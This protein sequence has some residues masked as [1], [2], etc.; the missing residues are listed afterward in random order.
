MNGEGSRERATQGGGAMTARRSIG[1]LSRTLVC[2]CAALAL[3]AG[4]AQGAAEPHPHVGKLPGFPMI[5]GVVPVLGSKAAVSAHEKLVKDAFSTVRA[6]HAKGL[7]GAPVSNEEP[8][9]ECEE[10]AFFFASQD[11]CYRG[12]PVLRDPTVHLIFWQGPVDVKGEATTPEVGTFAPGYINT[13]EQYFQDVANESGTQT[14]VF[15]VDPQY[16]DETG[17]GEYALSFS[18]ADAEVRHD[19][20]PSNCID[21]TKYSKG[22]CL[23][24]S[25]LQKEVKTV[26]GGKT[27]LKDLY[28]VLTPPGVGGC[29]EA[30]SKECAYEQYC[31]YHSDFGGDGK[32][33]GGQTLYADLPFVGEVRGCDAVVHP[34]AF[35][36]NGADAVIDVGS[37][38]VNETVTDPIGSQC[39]EESK[40]IVGCERNAWTDAIGQEVG[41][42]CLPPEVTIDGIYGEPLGGSSA[43]TLYNQE[44]N[45][46]HYWAQRE[47]SNE[48]G[49]FEGACVQR[50]IGASFTVSA[51]AAA[52]VPV[53]LD[54]SASGAPGD[55]AVY[56]VWAFV[57]PVTHQIERQIGSAE[58]TVSYTYAKPGAYEVALTA[59][60]AYGNAQATVGAFNVGAAPVPPPPPSAPLPITI[61][62]PAGP[63]AHLTAA[64]LA[65]KLG[66]PANGKKLAGNGRIALGHAECPPACSVTLLLYAKVTATTH[67]HRST[68]LVSIGSLHITV[69]AKGTGSLSLVLN[70]KG[71]TMLRK[72]HTLSCRLLVTVEGQEGGSWQIVRSLTLTR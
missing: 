24:D 71:R 33:P 51:G 39:D 36:D 45:G 54:G 14:N 40:E 67:G 23:L 21:E 56:W 4:T 10:E 60:D 65:A 48:A 58:P 11:V 3:A 18:G 5:R 50:A 57:N 66:L 53:T 13:V 63:P 22:P 1:R 12:G 6:R 9:A 35:T 15:A 19:V 31:A 69:A 30:P 29:F 17:P 52:T 70:A 38:E 7:K 42:K 2:A 37:H 8:L 62:E 28:V 34:N 26:A 68:K 27:G 43:S 20:F 61:K 72:L 49:L 64:Q 32:T 16:G 44:I 46:H 25:D 55:P 47:W 41:D 59:Y